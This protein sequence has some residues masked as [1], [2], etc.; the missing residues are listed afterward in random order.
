MPPESRDAA[1]EKGGRRPESRDAAPER[2][3]AAPESRDA[4]PESRDAAPVEVGGAPEVEGG[5]A[6]EPNGAPVLEPTRRQA[7][8][9]GRNLVSSVEIGVENTRVL[10]THRSEPRLDDDFP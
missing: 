3:D 9:I 2:W 1:P 5:S 6:R 7:D 8:V 4:A 10:A